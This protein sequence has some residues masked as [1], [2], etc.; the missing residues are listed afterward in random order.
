MGVNKTQWHH[1]RNLQCG[2]KDRRYREM[3]EERGLKVV[4]C[5]ESGWEGG[6]RQQVSGGELKDHPGPSNHAP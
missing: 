3:N 4:G 6:D 2:V 1:K 5:K